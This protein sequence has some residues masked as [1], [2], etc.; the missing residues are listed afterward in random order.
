LGDFRADEFLQAR[1]QPMHGDRYRARSHP[2]PLRHGF[3]F[4]G[5]GA[6]EERRESLEQN[7]FSP[8]M[9]LLPQTLNGQRQSRAA[10]APIEREL[11]TQVFLDLNVRVRE[12]WRRDEGLL[13]RLGID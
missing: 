4:A 13:D 2:E 12:Q 3:I 11:G 7:I 10:P 8:R 5:I 1:P 9:V 6:V